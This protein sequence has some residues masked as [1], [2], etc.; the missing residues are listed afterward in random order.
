M[1]WATSLD[2]TSGWAV[3][4]ALIVVVQWGLHRVASRRQKQELVQLACRL[5]SRLKE[6][7]ES[8]WGVVQARIKSFC[9]E[10]QEAL[11]Q[12]R[13]S[14]AETELRR[15]SG[16]IGQDSN[17]VARL[18]KRHQVLALAQMGFDSRDIAKKLRL[19]RGETELMLG[20]CG[21]IPEVGVQHG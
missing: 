15:R 9:E 4:L 3:A 6:S 7:G 5:E 14:L 12:L 1:D 8:E 11:D 16:T 13:L 17:S 20:L 10:Q 19:S 21:S 18:D 2:S